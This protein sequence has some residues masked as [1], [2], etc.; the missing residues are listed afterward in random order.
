M[1][2]YSHLASCFLLGML[3]QHLLF[4]N[5]SSSSSFS[6]SLAAPENG[7]GNGNSNTN[8]QAAASAASAAAASSW[9][10][11]MEWEEGD[12]NPSTISYDFHLDKE[13]LIQ[14]PCGV[15]IP[16]AP[17]TTDDNQKSN[18]E[19]TGTTKHKQSFSTFPVETV[20][21]TA[22]R[23]TTMTYETA[24]RLGLMKLIVPLKL[25]HNCNPSKNCRINYYYYGYIPPKALQFRLG[26]EE[27]T[28]LAPAIAILS[29]QKDK[30]NVVVP[31]VLGL[32]FLRANH[33]IVDLRQEELHV[34]NPQG[35]DVMVPMIRP[36]AT[37][38][39][40]DD[41]DEPEATKNVCR[42]SSS[43]QN[44]DGNTQDS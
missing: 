24:Q 18:M 13:P 28:L 36:R 38:S 43:S 23:Q 34:M 35:I 2:Q 6:F 7:N 27:A 41:D 20:V 19:S 29:Q 39:F 31:L 32:D 40:G 8:N 33:A 26:S 1:K 22:A 10:D 14:V 16:D 17:T 25:G 21:D 30:Q 44:C 5:K 9:V 37:L 12:S 11:G 15:L 42:H 4:H 3:S